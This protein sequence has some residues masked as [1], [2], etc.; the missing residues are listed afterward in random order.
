MPVILPHASLSELVRRVPPPAEAVDGH[1][2]W[3]AAEAVLGVRL[4]TDFKAL[5]E[6]YGRGE[7]CDH[8]CL[9]TPF[10]EDN[11]VRLAAICS[12][13]TTACGRCSPRTSLSA[14]PRAGRADRVGGDGQRTPSVLAHR[15]PPDEWPVVV[16]SRDDDY[17]E[18]GPGTAD[19]LEGWITGRIVSEAMPGSHLDLAPWF[20][21]AREL[22]HVYVTLAEGERPYPERLRL[23]REALAPTADRGGFVSEADGLRQDHFATVEGG[24]EV[25]YETAYGHQI[26]AAFPSEDSE[27]A[28]LAVLGAA[29]LMGCEVLGLSTVHGTVV[30]QPL[31]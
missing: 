18:Y 5:V 26:R 2:D 12:R 15:G 31:P 6:T 22:A 29:R 16:W 21:S 13:T 17:E 11:P 25:T 14:L 10:G 27:R 24:W 7:F 3:E 4:P 20:D 19:F 1:G 23:L 30:W 9:R 8:I 28:R